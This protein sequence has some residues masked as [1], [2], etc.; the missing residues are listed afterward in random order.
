MPSVAVTTN[1]AEAQ[2][3][4]YDQQSVDALNQAKAQDPDALSKPGFFESLIKGAMRIF[5]SKK[6]EVVAE[7]SPKSLVQ[8]VSVPVTGPIS[9]QPSV[10]DQPPA[11]EAE[12]AAASTNA[13]ATEQPVVPASVEGS[14]SQ[15]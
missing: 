6:E 12:I 10:N 4:N 9:E 3:D 8:S 14:P 13:A 11:V 2:R 5:P 15:Q 1:N 7:K